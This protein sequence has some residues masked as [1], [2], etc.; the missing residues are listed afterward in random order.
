MELC[1]TFKR[2]DEVLISLQTVLIVG[3]IHLYGSLIVLVPLQTSLGWNR[4]DAPNVKTLAFFWVMRKPAATIRGY[5]RAKSCIVTLVG[6][7]LGFN[8]WVSLYARAYFCVCFFFGTYIYLLLMI[9]FYHFSLVREDCIWGWE[10][11]LTIY[12]SV[13]VSNA[14]QWTHS[15]AF[16]RSFMQL[17]YFILIIC[18]PWSIDHTLAE[19]KVL[20]FH[21]AIE[22]IL[23]TSVFIFLDDNIVWEWPRGMCI[24]LH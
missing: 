14:I 2:V 13:L 24:L 21:M 20:I 23:L 9:P 3:S 17:Y 1:A 6:K 5:R 18:N 4:L 7:G 15:D 8:I 22:C 10:G 19:F 12:G 16:L 11:I